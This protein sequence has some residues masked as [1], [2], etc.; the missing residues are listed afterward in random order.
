MPFLAWAGTGTFPPAAWLAIRGL[1]W[2]E[3]PIPLTLS[4]AVLFW[5]VGFDILYACQDTEFDQKTGLRSIPAK[6]G[7][8]NALRLAFVC[9]LIMLVF[10]VAFYFLASPPLGRIYLTGVALTGGLVIYQHTLVKP[11]DLNR[12]N[13]A[14]FQ[15]NAVISLGMLAVVILQLQLGW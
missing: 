5:V 10:L 11:N 13:L 4:G 12:V 6:L 7:V 1:A 9:H 2:N 14:F 8:A 3:A 15:V